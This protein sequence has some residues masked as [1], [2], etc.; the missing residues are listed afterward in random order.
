M[1]L[2][3]LLMTVNLLRLQHTG[4]CGV[5]FIIKGN[6]TL[7]LVI[8]NFHKCMSLVMFPVVCDNKMMYH[9]NL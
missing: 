7:Q 3:L 1:I 5:V 9:Q 4:K 2:K 8:L 6:G